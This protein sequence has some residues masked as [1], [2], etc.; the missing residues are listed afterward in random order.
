[1]GINI[2]Q[3]IFI[4]RVDVGLLRASIPALGILLRLRYNF[5]GVTLRPIFHVTLSRSP[6][7]DSPKGQRRALF[8]HPE[9]ARPKGLLMSSRPRI[10]LFP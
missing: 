2:T 6:E 10:E 1:L 5:K 7:G 4:Y 3:K 8:C 9:A